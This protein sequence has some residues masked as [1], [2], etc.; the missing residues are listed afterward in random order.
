MIKDLM[1]HYYSSV[2]RYTTSGFMK[3]NLGDALKDRDL[4]PHI[5]E[6]AD[7][8]R[9]QLYELDQEPAH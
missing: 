3:T 1:D 9:R 5:Y 6:T 8:A 7:E 2:T 4:A